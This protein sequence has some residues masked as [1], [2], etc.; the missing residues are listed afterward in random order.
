MK[1][2]CCNA[3][4]RIWVGKRPI[5]NNCGKECE[6]TELPQ[7]MKVKICPYGF[8]VNDEHNECDCGNKH[9]MEERF[10]EKFRTFAGHTSE[11]STELTHNN[12][13]DWFKS[14]QSRLLN[15]VLGKKRR[16]YA[17]REDMVL[18]ED[19][20]SIAHEEGIEL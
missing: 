4:V 15:V 8:H 7:T 3:T 13:R 17:I 16:I 14:E 9:S 6:Y 18:T 2:T 19:I 1:S 12:A 20:L 10:N 11:G 5:C